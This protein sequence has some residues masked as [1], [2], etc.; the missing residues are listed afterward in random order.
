MI[1]LL[2][3]A[4][5][6]Q[7]GVA[8][9]LSHVTNDPFQRVVGVEGSAFWSPSP[10]FDVELRAAL[11]PLRGEPS[12]SPLA[13][14][15]IEEVQVAPDLSVP[16]LRV[17]AAGAFMPLRLDQGLWSARGGLFVGAGLVSTRDDLEVL[18][19]MGDDAFEGTQNEVHPTGLYGLDV[20]AMRGPLGCRVRTQ[21]LFYV[22]TVGGD[23][24]ES[25]RPTL[26][27]VDLLLRL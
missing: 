20:E 9:G 3:V 23:T 13:S 2:S 24:L 18:S 27:A 26:V 15:L 19:A 4:L 5:G 10:L 12:Y 16:R 1:A 11:H 6:A 8:V 22:E 21:R 25:K 7:V 14:Q 17:E